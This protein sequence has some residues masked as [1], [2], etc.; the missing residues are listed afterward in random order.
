MESILPQHF[1]HRELTMVEVMIV[2][3]LLTSF[4]WMVEEFTKW[5][6]EHKQDV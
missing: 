2:A 1:H 6:Q 5:L 4:L 3:M